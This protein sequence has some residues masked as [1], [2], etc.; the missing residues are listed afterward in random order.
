MIP[1]R[2]VLAEVHAVQHVIEGGDPMHAALYK[3]MNPEEA[4]IPVDFGDSPLSCE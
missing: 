4:E 2:A 1:P 3:D